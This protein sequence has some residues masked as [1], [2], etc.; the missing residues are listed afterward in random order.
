[1]SDAMAWTLIVGF[2][3]ITA[4]MHAYQARLY[5]SEIARLEAKIDHLD[6]DVQ[7]VVDRIFGE[8]R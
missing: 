6:R 5:R 8:G 1:M 3:T 7:R 2:L 4:V